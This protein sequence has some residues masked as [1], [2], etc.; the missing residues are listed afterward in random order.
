[1]KRE[2]ECLSLRIQRKARQLIIGSFQKQRMQFNDKNRK[3]NKIVS[4]C[5]GTKMNERQN[6]NKTEF[7]NSL[8]QFDTKNV[9]K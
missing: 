2:I 6:A 7:M 3:L 4:S 8:T 5:S 1:M 9:H